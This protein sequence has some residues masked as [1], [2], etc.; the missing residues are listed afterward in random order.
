MYKRPHLKY[1][2]SDKQVNKEQRYLL[3]IVGRVQIK[4]KISFYL[5]EI[6]QALEVFHLP[7]IFTLKF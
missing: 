4:E 3:Y 1:S 6:R 2:L 5:R 7:I